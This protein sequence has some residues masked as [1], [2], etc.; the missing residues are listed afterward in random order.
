MINTLKYALISAAVLAAAPSIYAGQDDAAVQAAVRAAIPAH[1]GF[2]DVVVKKVAVNDRTR[3]VT[4]SC[5]ENA[6]YMPLTA[7]TLAALKADIQSRINAKYRDYTVSITADGRDL[8]QLLPY[9]PKRVKGPT[10][11]VGFVRRHD[12]PQ[13]GKGLDGSNIAL[14]QS[15]GWYY[16]PSLNRWEFQRAR[17]FQTVE[18]LYTQSYVLPYLIP[19]LENAGAYVM[20]PRERDLSSTEEIIDRDGG[21][22]G[23]N[24]YHETGRWTNGDAPGFAMPA[25]LL[26]EGV[27]PF[28]LGHYRVAKTAEHKA[29]TAA[30]RVT[31]PELKGTHAVYVS[32]AS[33]PNSATDALYEIHAADG[34]HRV[35]V[36]Q[37]MGGST[38]V[39]LGSYP[40]D[41]TDAD[42][43]T[44]KLIAQ[45]ADPDAVVSADAV[46]VGGGI[47]NVA[48]R[49]K[50]KD[51]NYM[52]YVSTDYP[53][54]TGAAKYQLQWA[55]APDS[56]YTP[57]GEVKDYTDDYRSRG[58][59]V[60]WLA[61]GSSMLPGRQG[62]NIPVDLSFAW[63]TDAGTTMNDDIIGTL[64]IYCTAG[65][66][67]GN[68]STRM[69]SR[70]L[71]QSVMTNIVDVI[72]S[73]YEPNWTRRGMWDE[74]YAEARSP[75][76]PAML[77]ELLSHQNFADMKYGLDPRFRFDVSRAV[78]RGMLEF[79]GK[80]DGREYVVQP[81]PVNTFAITPAAA[82]SYTLSWAATPDSLAP[83]AV[84]TYYLVQERVADGAFRTVA[85]VSE[86][87][88]TA[89]VSDT[90][91]HSY[92]IVAGNDGGV[93]FP[94][95]VLALRHDPKGVQALIVNGF[96]R[97]GAPFWFDSGE[98]AG[99]YDDYDSG[100][101]DVYDIS[102]IGKMIEY[103]RE[104]P[105]MDDDASG[106][107]SS[108][109][110]YETK[111]LAGNTHDYAYVHGQMLAQAGCG[112]VSM[113]L[114]AYEAQGAPAGT[115]LIDL[116]LGKQRESKVGR[117]AFGSE[118]KTFGNALQQRISADTQAG[119]SM[120]VS[121]SYVASDLADNPLSS[122][123]TAKADKEWAAK[124]LG[125]NWR[126]GQATDSGAAVTV[127]TPTGIERGIEV[128]FA[129]RPNADSYAVES[130]DALI[131]ANDNAMTFMRYNNGLSA[132]T[133]YNAGN[134][135]AAV[136]GFPLET[137]H[138]IAGPKDGI[139]RL[140]REIVDYLT[141][142]K[143]RD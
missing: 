132:A 98:L 116:I 134:Y 129:Q 108:R 138:L 36:N 58:L 37:R 97:V 44:I 110:E 50:D 7:E 32:Y 89:T 12:L 55:G 45:S 41:P 8:D 25:D 78:Y 82:G 133:L 57:S 1:S 61:G 15:H 123:E 118:F 125:Y 73:K 68:G 99:F 112:F 17:I 142:G 109:T 22:H 47:I 51:G 70:D 20:T 52:E 124:T 114:A 27:N 38:W 120:L 40:L 59:W 63:H 104:I 31:D 103:R 46:K 67:L 13:I 126:V 87:I 43:S 24:A 96:T 140:V 113:S 135:R 28:K 83:S 101:A 9:A 131:P 128:A 56:V 119:I 76:V 94:S 4:V 77:L 3:T 10:E 16:E 23:K 115:R 88:Y 75:E 141:V 6:A 86:P 111:V 49:T 74:S 102:Y 72:R 34:V 48:R 127:Q 84:P 33:L 2:G 122:K 85:T 29:P 93:S 18:D 35:N 105:W 60:N 107:G 130:P 137:S 92:R 95:E 81:L 54:Y 30:W 42:K 139:N 66:T 143:L 91:I 71:T 90:K 121:G 80:R 64:G 39:Y 53:R 11:A 21:S 136:I 106:F 69:A 5:N 79:I 117:G 26:T 65:D 62:L 100:V 14:W 19:M